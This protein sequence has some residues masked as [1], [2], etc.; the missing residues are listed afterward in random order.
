MFHS[1][2]WPCVNVTRP[3]P[4]ILFGAL[5]PPQKNMTRSPSKESHV[6]LSAA[7]EMSY[8]SASFLFFVFLILSL[9]LFFLKQ[10]LINGGPGGYL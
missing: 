8:I 6:S 3:S 9:S 10:S 5:P 1:L 4:A 7:D 2:T